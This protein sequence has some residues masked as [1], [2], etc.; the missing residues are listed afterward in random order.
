MNPETT[1]PRTRKRFDEAFKRSAVAHWQS[2]GKSAAQ[3]A[4]ELGLN[5]QSLK[6][7][8][9]SRDCG[10]AAASPTGVRTVAELEAENRRLRRE[11]HAV[12]QQR[13]ILKKPWASSPVPATTF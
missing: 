4:S 6:Q 7:W 9:A 8:K 10:S 3:V 2:S 12:A 11:L 13:D 5:P 1:T